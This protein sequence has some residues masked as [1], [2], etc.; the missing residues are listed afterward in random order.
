MLY[1]TPRCKKRHARPKNQPNQSRK[2]LNLEKIA[3]LPLFFHFGDFWASMELLPNKGTFYPGRRPYCVVSTAES[4]LGQPGDVSY[5]SDSILHGVK[6]SAPKVSENKCFLG[7]R[8]KSV[9]YLH[10]SARHWP[11]RPRSFP[12]KTSKSI[13]N[14]RKH[15]KITEMSKIPDGRVLSHFFS[16]EGV[17]NPANGCFIWFLGTKCVMPD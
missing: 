1:L 17:P 8:Q 9:R 13:K 16:R 7:Q 11:C 4:H 14:L 6:S 3:C 10:N 5:A 12:S 2:S 15:K